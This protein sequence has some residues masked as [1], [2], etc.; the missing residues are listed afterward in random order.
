MHAYSCSCVDGF[1]GPQC[2]QTRISFPGGGSPSDGGSW[3]WFD[4]LSQCDNSH[5]SFELITARDSGLI[6]YYGPMKDLSA[7]TSTS[8]STWVDVL[9]LGASGGGGV[10]PEDFLVIEMRAG[11]PVVRV[12]MG[13]GETRLTID[14]RDRNGQQRIGKLSDGRWHRI[15]VFISGQVSGN[16]RMSVIT[17]ESI[18][19]LLSSTVCLLQFCASSLN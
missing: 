14:G 5:T 18:E 10:E 4:G 13:T 6:A 3:A 11:F 1:D 19:Y 16:L 9:L 12:N 17:V 7:T 15:D 8:T 2:Q